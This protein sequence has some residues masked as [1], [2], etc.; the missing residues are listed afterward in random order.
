MKIVSKDQA[1]LLAH[2]LEFENFKLYSFNSDINI[3]FTAT[4]HLAL[5][6]I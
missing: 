4:D 2:L 6:T 5:G 1:A 3:G